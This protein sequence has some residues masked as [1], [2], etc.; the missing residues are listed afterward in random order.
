M[1]GQVAVASILNKG[2]QFISP[3]NCPFPFNFDELPPSIS[4]PNWVNL[5]FNA[6]GAHQTTFF[7]D[8]ARRCPCVFRMRLSAHCTT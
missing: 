6:T 4:S 5:D 7:A 3:Y 8:L 1:P 2:N